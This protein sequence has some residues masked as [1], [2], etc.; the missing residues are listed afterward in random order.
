[1]LELYLIEFVLIIGF[2]YIVAIKGEVLG[3]GNVILDV[4]FLLLIV[5]C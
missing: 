4:Y 5:F 3:C 1:M 2:F